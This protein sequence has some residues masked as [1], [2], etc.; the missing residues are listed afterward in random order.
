MKVLRS[1]I[2]F[3]ALILSL[4]FVLILI[5]G[6]GAVLQ[7]KNTESTLSAPAPVESSS[8]L[9]D[10]VLLSPSDETASPS[11]EGPEYDTYGL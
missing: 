1:R 3:L 10:N 6:T 9:P 4:L 5:A 11:P 8:P 2:R 7:A